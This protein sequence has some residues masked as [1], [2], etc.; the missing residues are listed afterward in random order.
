M[1]IILWNQWRKSAHSEFIFPFVTYAISFF[2]QIDVSS[3]NFIYLKRGKFSLH[4]LQ[5]YAI[6]VNV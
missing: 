3:Y 1:L 6:F 5:G 2:R 4:A